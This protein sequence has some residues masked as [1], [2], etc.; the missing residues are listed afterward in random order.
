MS[1]LGDPTLP[2]AMYDIDSSADP[3][4]DSV[5]IWQ[6]RAVTTSELGSLW[7]QSG[8]ESPSRNAATD[9]D[10]LVV[11]PGRPEHTAAEPARD[12]ATDGR[13][14]RLRRG[15][16]RPTTAA[17][18]R[19]Q[20]PERNRRLSANAP[21]TIAAIALAVITALGVWWAVTTFGSSTASDASGVATPEESDSGVIVSS[22]VD[23]SA[24][25]ESAEAVGAVESQVASEVG[26]SDDRANTAAT[27]TGS[28]SGTDTGAGALSADQVA[29]YRD[30]AADEGQSAWGVLVDGRLY[31]EGV[32]RA[33]SQS[34]RMA[35]RLR[36][37]LGSDNVVENYVVDPIRAEGDDSP[38]F[39]VEAVELNPQT[40]GLSEDADLF[41]ALAA[42]ML[43][44]YPETTLAVWGP[45]ADGG[46]GL[47]QAA[48]DR[49]IANGID[50]ERVTVE[51]RN[52]VDLPFEPSTEFIVR[53][54]AA[55]A[56]VA[57]PAES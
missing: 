24:R 42:L 33:E 14:S 6:A 4:H 55:Q 10:T 9:G 17:R 52:T 15:E 19:H 28:G 46:A 27:Q 35:E 37:V 45:G 26:E 11:H 48:V 49:L 13:T 50:Q 16:H 12:Q 51:E 32:V 3:M 43:N 41:M 53:G 5:P 47:A 23:S 36:S 30:L 20:I 18:A 8:G 57:A 21:G 34:E 39:I 38:L 31:L 54:L 2:I 44:R 56:K 40:G 25:P 7:A 1:N 22:G 29:Y